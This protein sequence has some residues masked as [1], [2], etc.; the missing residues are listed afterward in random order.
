[1]PASVGV[2]GSA[3][4]CRVLQP[5]PVNGP[6]YKGEGTAAHRTVG[7]GDIGPS[8]QAHCPVST[9]VTNQTFQTDG[10]VPEE[11]HDPKNGTNLQGDDDQQGIAKTRKAVEKVTTANPDQDVHIYIIARKRLD[12]VEGP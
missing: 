3:Q 6:A 7:A 5:V 1:M 8:A 10:E 11:K 12:G 2:E 4:D 9:P